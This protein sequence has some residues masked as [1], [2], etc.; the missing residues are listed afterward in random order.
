MVKRIYKNHLIEF[1]GDIQF[2]S[3]YDGDSARVVSD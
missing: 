3:D 1:M 2:A